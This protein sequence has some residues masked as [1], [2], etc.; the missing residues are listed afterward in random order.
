MAES[1]YI[2]GI[3]LGTTNSVVS[4][5]DLEG[6][7]QEDAAELYPENHIL[8]IPQITDPGIVEELSYLPSFFY[9]PGETELPE[10]G[11]ALPWNEG[12][13][14]AVGRFAMKRGA[15]VPSRLVSSAKSWLCHSDVDRTSAIL[16]WKAHKSI[17]KYSPLDISSNYLE[18]IRNTWNYLMTGDNPDH[19]LENQEVYITVPASFDVVARDLTAKA[20]KKAGL[21]K[22][23]LLEEP[24]AAFYAW[25]NRMKNEWR[26]KVNVGDVIL[27]C[28]IGG[29]TTDLSLILVTEEKGDLALNRIAVGDHILLGGDNMDLTL[30]YSVR[31]HFTKEGIKLDSY[32]MLGLV[33]NCRDAKERILSDPECKTYNVVILGRGRSVVG[34]TIQTDLKRSEVEEIILNGFFPFCDIEDLPVEQKAVGFKELGL[35]YASDPSVTKHLSRFLKQH[36]QKTNDDRDKTF[37]HPTKILFNGG[38][39]KASAIRDRIVDVLNSWLSNENAEP[40]DV[41]EGNDPD[42]AVALGSTYY[43]F[44]KKGKGIR[45]KGG[46]GRAYYVAVESSMPAVPGMA[47]PIKAVCV[48]PFGTE[49]GS[50]GIDIDL[51]GQEFGLVVGEQVEFRF[52][53]STVRKEDTYGDVLEEWDEEEIIELAPLE[54]TLTA[55]DLEETVVPVKLHSILNEMGTLELWCE[56]PDSK[57]KWK[58]E[59]NLRGNE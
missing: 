22:V 34:G 19:I 50:E 36:L 45:I 52:L 7:F 15:E 9:I 29:G 10:K 57:N 3:D 28:D 35:H 4:Y 23:A 40:V 31:N 16:P 27:V 11:L 48:V 14:Y 42:M 20:A 21:E 17:K 24:Q 39:I 32:Q 46:V 49:E 6:E 38:V 12:I 37:I 47:P 59:F 25:I 13:P 1:R 56:T 54:T 43:G 18:H 55:K 53:S 51:P 2:V 58:L 5:L 44:A 41:I 30:A 26:E 33:H 8:N